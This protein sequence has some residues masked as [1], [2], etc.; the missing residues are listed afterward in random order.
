M[1][2]ALTPTI[3]LVAAGIFLLRIGDTSLD[4]IRMLF[5]M[6]GRKGLAWALAFGQALLFVV[7]ISTVLSHLDNAFT[8]LAYAAG[9]A[10]GNVVGMFIEE[11]MAIG[12]MQFTIISSN[13]G[14]VVASQL[15]QNGFAVTEIPARGQNGTVTMLQT[16]VKRKD[17]GNIEKIVLDADPAAFVTLDETRPVRRGYWRA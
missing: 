17:M 16:N 8:I 12:F 2:F 15:R 7:A 9:F 1:S 10:T 13:R 6:R 11:R 5:V 14:A 4:T 3:L